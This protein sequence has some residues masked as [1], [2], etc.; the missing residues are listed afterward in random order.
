MF[1]FTRKPSAGSHNQYLAKNTGLVQCSYNVDGG[2]PSPDHRPA[3]NWVQHTTSCIAQS[4]AP[5]DGQNCC[6]KHVELI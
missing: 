5:E 1:R 6:P 3:T 2:T 4:N